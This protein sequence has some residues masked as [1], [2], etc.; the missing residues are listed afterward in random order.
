[1]RA[2]NS[3]ACIS[4]AV[5]LMVGA[6]CSKGDFST[7]KGAARTF[8]TAMENGD[9]ETAKK[10]CAG[11]DPKMLESMVVA[12]GNFKKMHDAAISKFGDEGKTVFGETVNSFDLNRNLDDA[13]EK[14]D[15]DQATV[16]AK[17]GKTFNLKK[18]NGEWKVDASEM[19]GPSGSVGV[20]MA[21]SMGKSAKELADEINDGKYKTAAEAKDAFSKKMLGG[22]GGLLK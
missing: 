1:M 4:L 20:A 14:I 19:S 21:E 5:G 11:G 7:P 15:G 13:V 10:A 8:A 3:V 2:I 6:G 18:V 22:M 9:T 12:V 16:T 17:G